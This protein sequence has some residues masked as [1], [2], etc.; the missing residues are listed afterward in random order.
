MVITKIPTDAQRA[1]DAT[2]GGGASLSG[3][4]SPEG[5]TSAQPG[6]TYVDTATG[7]F[8][9]KQ[10]GT[11]SSGWALVVG[12]SGTVF[13]AIYLY[14]QTTGKHTPIQATGDDGS[15]T[16]VLGDDVTV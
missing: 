7:A 9:A 3:S 10:T 15:K 14:N 12:T 1:A 5:T 2:S 6:V 8:Y 16:L 13:D 11:G 4:G